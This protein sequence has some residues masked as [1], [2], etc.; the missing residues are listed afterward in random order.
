[1]TIPVALR[2]GQITRRWIMRARWLP[3]IGV[4]ALIVASCN[5]GDSI[6]TTT[7]ATDVPSTIVTNVT[8]A[9]ATTQPADTTDTTEEAP[10]SEPALRSLVAPVATITVDGDPSDWGVVPG[11]ALTL[12][13]IIAEMDEGLE[14]KDV[15]F[16][17]AYDDENVYA[18]FTVDDD[19]DWNPD[20]NKLS[21]ALAVMFPVD[22]GGPHMGAD[23]EE[24]ET[25]TGMVD[26]WHWEL[27]CASGV[28]SGGAVNPPGDGKDPGNDSVC[29]FDDEWA[30][31]AET[32]EDDNAA[33]AENTLFGVWK[34]S[35]PTA[36]TPGVWYFEM[37]RPLQTG[38]SQDA[39]FTAGESTLLA[40]A[41]WDPD[42]G[43]DGWHDD[44][45]VQSSNQEW[46]QVDFVAEAAGDVE[47]LR[48]LV[49][50]VAT[51]TVDGDP[52]DWGVVPGLALTLEPI[53]A[54]MDEGLENKDVTFKMA[55][56]DENVYALF[57]VDDDYDWNP[58]DNKLSAALAVMFPVDTGGPHMGADD[59]EGETSTGMVDIW[60]WELDC[61]SGV[62][63]G[64]AV[65]PPGDGK[66]PG[67]DSVCNF[68]D[69]WATDAET[70][71]DD[72]AAGAENTLFGVWKH[73][74]PTAGTPGVWYF[75]MSR[76]LQTGDSQDAQFTAGESTLLALA[77]WD[78][79]LGP[80]GWH[81]DSHVQSSNQEWIQVD[82]N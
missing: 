41:Y 14:N 80:D 40:L 6:D 50:P 1:M 21:A 22:T 25:S 42:L 7:T 79:D 69:E 77:Y 12:E 34:H 37:S 82:F 28:D 17:M 59:E 2:G 70:R 30:T 51:I 76:P 20:D 65:N 38:D 35:N 39:Q 19:Y 27:D 8:D 64:G 49:A 56:D 63:S 16:K 54:E 4:L 58:D 36:G 32:R 24:G 57:T 11:L 67:N 29:N 43:P 47:A 53:I 3:I 23:D 46:I 72:N 10:P 48:S 5:S 66:D 44:S 71:E 78:P 62:D 26:I 73:S 60:H 13:P 52:S 81:D 31:D 18:L 45:H 75:E 15:T 74:N 55:Y 68:D 33:G 9:P 61:A